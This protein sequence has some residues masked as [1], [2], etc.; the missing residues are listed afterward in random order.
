MR[1]EQKHLTWRSGAYWRNIA[2]ALGCTILLGIGIFG[3]AL[4]MLL[5]QAA[6]RPLHPPPKPLERL[7]S[8]YGIQDY[9]AVTF[10]TS[11]GVRLS[12]WYI[13]PQNG[14]VI[15]FA[16]GYA[17]NRTYF[18]P[19]A[20]LLVEQGFG[21]LLFDFRGHGTSQATT[22]TIGDHERRDVIAALDFVSAQSGVDPDRI[23]VVAHSMGAA[24]VIQVAAEDERLRALVLIAPFPT[25]EAV[26]TDGFHVPGIIRDAVAAYLAWRE[27]VQIDDV[28]PVDDLC[29][30][31]PRPVLLIFGDQDD[32]APPGSQEIMFAAACAGTETWLVAG[33]NHDDVMEIEPIAYPTRLVGFFT[34][35]ILVTN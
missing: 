34:K 15:I 4:I 26:I 24:T 16:H 22:V 32:V 11:D 33:A 17:G 30:I 7:P 20:A 12:G 6:E 19:Q 29:A 31:S 28:R 2:R 8:D 13:P 3:V 5:V 1:S 35:F 23:G 9:Q 25:L 10:T 27:D 14:A 21:A 18:L